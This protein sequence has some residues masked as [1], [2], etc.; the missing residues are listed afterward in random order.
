MNYR[1]IMSRLNSAL[2]T[3][4]SAYG[5]IAKKYGLSFNALMIVC[6]IYESDTITQKVICDTL[7]LPKS[8]VHSIL[9]NLMK[10]EYIVLKAGNDKKEKFVTFTELG[11]R[12]FEVVLTETQKFEDK[13]LSALDTGTCLFLVETAEKLGVIINDE[14]AELSNKEE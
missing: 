14:I 8:T 4:D 1:D 10:Q 3:I 6:L 2:S 11:V 5:V 13:I 7:H 9:L 12:Y